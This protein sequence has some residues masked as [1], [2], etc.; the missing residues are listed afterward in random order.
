MASS[1]RVA[2]ALAALGFA[3]A[4]PTRRILKGTASPAP[5]VVA[6]KLLA[7]TFFIEQEKPFFG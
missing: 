7:A 6:L 5:Q 1:V 4:A 3:K 2:K